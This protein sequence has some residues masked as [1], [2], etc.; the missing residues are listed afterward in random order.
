MTWLDLEEMTLGELLY[1]VPITEG[2][3]LRGTRVC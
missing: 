3:M 1:Y 2:E